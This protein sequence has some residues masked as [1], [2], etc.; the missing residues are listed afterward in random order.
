MKALHRLAEW[1]GKCAR[2][3]GVWTKRNEVTAGKNYTIK[4]LW[5]I[6]VAAC[7]KAC[8]C[9][10]SI[11]GAAG[12]NPAGGVDFCLLYVLCVVSADH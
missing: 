2:T 1:Y 4:T 9:C 7:F 10:R 5:P 8:V 12:S 6:T 3:K 11:A